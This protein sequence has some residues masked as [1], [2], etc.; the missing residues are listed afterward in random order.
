MYFD[1]DKFTPGEKV[2]TL[3][4][5]EKALLNA[6]EP[7]TAFADK[8]K[9]LRKDIADKVFNEKTTISSLR[10]VRDIKDILKM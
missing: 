3:G 8:Y 1:Y 5:L 9:K 7:D 6:C 4:A 10:L 2:Q